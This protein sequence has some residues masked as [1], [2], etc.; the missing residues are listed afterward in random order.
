MK[1]L[2][3]ILALIVLLFTISKGFGQ[4]YKVTRYAD[5]NGLPSRIVRDVMQDNDGF[6]W[7]AGNNGLYKF[8]GQEFTPFLASLKDTIGLRDNKITAL[9]Q[10]SDNKIWIGTPR[11]LHI[12]ENNQIKH[13]KLI[14]N[15]NDN[16]QYV[17]NLFEDKNKNLWVG[18][19]GGLFLMQDLEK[20]VHFL[21]EEVD[22]SIA[23]AVIWGV[24]GDSHGRVWISGHD[25]PYILKEGE[26]Y[27]FEKLN[28]DLKDGVSQKETN[29]FKYIHYNDSLFLVESSKGLL[30]GTIEN[31]STITISKFRNT[32][33]NYIENHSV[34]RTIID[35]ENNIWVG[36]TKN[37]FK[38][39]KL[40]E[41]QLL[42]TEII[43]KNGF[44]GMSGNVKSIFEDAQ[45]NIWMANTNGLYKLSKD[46]GEISSFP[47]RYIEN[48]LKDLYGI[49]AM[50]EDKGGHLWITTPEK[51][52]RFKK[53]NLLEGKCPEDYLVFE[54]ENMQLSRNLLI[55]SQNRLWIGADGGLFVTQLDQNF[56]P[57]K[58]IR[59]TKANGLPHNQSFDIY[60]ENK[61]N[62]WIG[63]CEAL[64]KLTLKNGDL[65]HPEI[66]VFTDDIDQPDDLV[67]SHVNEIEVDNEGQ[68][69]LGTF[70]GVSRLM[71]ESAEGKFA[72]YTS[73]Y[74]SFNRL[75][76]N[77]IKKIFRDSQNRIWIATQRGLNLYDAG[78][79]EFIQ[80][81][82]AEGLPSEYVLGIQEDSNQFLWIATTNGVVKTK[83]NDQNQ[84]FSELQHFTSQSGLI[85]NIPYRNSIFIDSNDNV[86]LGSRDGLSIFKSFT[87][88]REKRNFNLAITDIESIQKKKKGFVSINSR[89][90]DYEITLS[91][92]E[93]SIKV[94]YAVL[95]FTNT[96]HNA[97]RHKFLPLNE[98]WVETGAISELTYYSLAPGD[99]ELI[100]DGS[101]N[102]GKW[103]ENPIKLK[104]SISPPYWKSNLAY[105]LYGLLI[106]GL[107]RI[108]YLMRIRKRIQELERKI[109]L[110]KAILN[111]RELLRQ[112][113]AQDFH[114]ELGSKLTKASLF[115]TLAERSLKQQEDPTRWFVKIRN[116]IK[117]LSGS[118]RDLLWVI[119]PQKDS[120]GDT[121]LRLKDFGEDLFN[122]TEVDFRTSGYKEEQAQ[123]MLDSQT[124]KQ[125]ILIFK[126]A[127]NNCTKY[128]N[129]NQI[130]LKL[131]SNDEGLTIEL[132]DNGKGFN[133]KSKSKGRG[134]KNMAERAKKIGANINITSNGSGTTISLERIPHMSDEYLV[135][136][137]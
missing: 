27:Y 3:P 87:G 38:K 62:F 109:K 44:F 123:I 9:V 135:E 121:F 126:E 83:Y 28:I 31:D 100:L 61:N 98:D 95:D 51:L 85:D 91:H 115:L 73:T 5:D 37:R 23:E 80:F 65:N 25:G 48:C 104:L 49:Y 89:I 35:Y 66:K 69:W 72:N 67:N 93:N 6:I 103:S 84:S 107:L 90:N 124:K 129:C 133:V 105:I 116:N 46:F 136:E 13:V 33:G 50:I 110:D 19:Y 78:K 102:Q 76:N 57:G 21:P 56:N 58:F 112:E 12:L 108:S 29:F 47:P 96:K 41:G 45:Q 68:L 74:G 42:E 114:D 1:K 117:E 75:S 15:P 52:Y 132:N 97:Y 39:F 40:I 2:F 125:V 63:N 54:D 16:Q 60:E 20:I 22:P 64:I 36:T 113:N 53:S 43:S 137:V 111:E 79:D 18:T 17:L 24:T 106:A 8:D 134:L 55:D 88:A 130:L 70:S 101:N 4:L 119:D 82:N 10:T 92:L 122:A 81:G 77:S 131:T 30:K 26:A 11:G 120:L 59:Y 86:F 118:F 34:E 127:I 71:D 128:A 94:S 99:Y 32:N 7:V 14:D